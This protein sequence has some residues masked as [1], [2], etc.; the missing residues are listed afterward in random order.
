MAA[1]FQVPG[2]E[3]GT[4]HNVIVVPEREAGLSTRNTELMPSVVSPA[5]PA[6]RQ[7]GGGGRRPGR[8]GRT[9]VCPRLARR[10]SIARTP[11]FAA[12]LRAAP[13]L[14]VAPGPLVRRGS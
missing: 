10:T 12:L 3:L 13:V 7:P 4:T 5:W 6:G 8:R 14:R 11:A 9:P 1:P 2:S